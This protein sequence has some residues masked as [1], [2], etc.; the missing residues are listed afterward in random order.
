[1]ALEKVAYLGAREALGVVAKLRKDAV[2]IVVAQG[3]SE[4]KSSRRFAVVPQCERR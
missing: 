2:R 4:D 3:D 1:M